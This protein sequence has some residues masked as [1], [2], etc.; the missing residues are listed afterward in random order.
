MSLKCCVLLMLGTQWGSPNCLQAFSVTN[1][2]NYHLSP[3]Q[4]CI[5]KYYSESVRQ[6]Q[7]SNTFFGHRLFNFT[8]I[9]KVPFYLKRYKVETH[10]LQTSAALW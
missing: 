7:V 9:S 4:S 1:V 3:P 8:S 5:K 2:S 10:F 6:C